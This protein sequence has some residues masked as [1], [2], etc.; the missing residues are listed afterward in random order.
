[1]Y[2][3]VDLTNL[4]EM[5]DGDKDVE[6]ML[7]EEFFKSANA[8]LSGLQQF[9]NSQENDQWRRN[10]HAFK[11]IA[12]NIGAVQLSTLCKQAQDG[13]TLPS[14]QKQLMLDTI[15]TEYGLVEQYLRQL[16]G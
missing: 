14:Q 11:G 12:L 15:K 6:T 4:R 10:A 16:M 2:I 3:P 7:F 5:T 1:M 13:M 9:H 8:C